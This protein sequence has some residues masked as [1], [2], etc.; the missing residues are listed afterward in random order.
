MASTKARKPVGIGRRVVPVVP[1]RGQDPPVVLLGEH[2]QTG[3]PAR[4]GT[5]ADHLRAAQRPG[6]PAKV[7]G[8]V[9]QLDREL[10]LR[11]PVVADRRQ[12]G[13]CPAAAP[14]RVDDQV[15]VDDLLGA[16]GGAHS[17][18][19]GDAVPGRVGAEADDLAP[20]HD[21]DRGQRTDPGPDAAFE[22]GPAGLADEGLGRAAPEAERTTGR[23]EAEL[24]EVPDRPARRRPPGRRGV[25]GRARRGS[26]SRRAPAGVRAGPA[27]RPAGPRRCPA[28]GRVPGP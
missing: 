10:L 21:L 18:H 16:A 11:R 24:R 20:I 26:R 27:G 14:G 25:P 4:L 23:S 9:L 22:V 28:A 5:D 13:R 3:G 7:S 15:G 19:P 17:P 2:H 8:G 1:D 6:T 12:P